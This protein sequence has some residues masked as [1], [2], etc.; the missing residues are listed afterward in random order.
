MKGFSLEF[1]IGA[2]VSE[3]LND[4]AFRWSKKVSD[5]FSRF[6][7]IPDCDSQPPSHVAVAITLNA[8]V[9]ML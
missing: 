4:G 3:N 8:N 9:K 1:C 2:E 5:R 6:D 7:T